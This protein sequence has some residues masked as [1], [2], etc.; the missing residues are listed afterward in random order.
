VVEVRH[1][2]FRNPD[3]IAL[4]REHGVAVVT[5]GDYRHGARHILAWGERRFL[6]HVLLGWDG[7]QA[8]V[9]PQRPHNLAA[10]RLVENLCRRDLS[11]KERAFGFRELIS[12]AVSPLRS[13]DE[14]ASAVGLR[15]SSAYNYWAVASGPDDV[16]QAVADEQITTLADAARIAVMPAAAARAQAIAA[17]SAAAP[18]LTSP[19]PLS[20][21]AHVAAP[22]PARKAGRP[23]TG[24]TLGRL[25][26]PD[27]V[28]YIAEH[29]C[30][31]QEFAVYHKVDWTDLKAAGDILRQIIKR[32]ERRQGQGSK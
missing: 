24:V 2:S 13:A 1:E 28:R 27:V 23:A 11:L 15:R 4:A 20:S 14:L 18:S 30:T 25:K 10:M 31:K 26:D 3:F 6:A 19:A 21:D 7:I 29:L 9:I 16:L 8:K 5:A 17:I 12:D 22:R 32:I